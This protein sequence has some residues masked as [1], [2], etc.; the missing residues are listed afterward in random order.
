NKEP[1]D[2]SVRQISDSEEPRDTSARHI[3]YNKEPIDTSAQQ[4]SDNEEP[5]DTSAEQISDSEG[6]TDTSAQRNNNV[7][8]DVLYP[9]EDFFQT[10]VESDDTDAVYSGDVIKLL[11]EIDET[12]AESYY[13]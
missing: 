3:P 13:Y 11:S 10:L 8:S 12:V 4:I 2:T 1:R 7:N 9:E 5:I 6:P